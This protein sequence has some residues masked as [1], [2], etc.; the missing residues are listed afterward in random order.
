MANPAQTSLDD[1]ATAAQ[2]L[3]T[4]SESLATSG[5]SLATSPEDL[6]TTQPKTPKE[7]K[8]ETFKIML[9]NL[10]ISNSTRNNVAELFRRYGYEYTFHSSNV[11]DI[12]SV[13]PAAATAA[14]RKLRKLGVIESP[15]CGVYQFVKK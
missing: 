11:A 4:V 13:K 2:D 9:K 8:Q 15:K 6:V 5:Q 12:F 7:I 1:V 10:P 3:A 14:L